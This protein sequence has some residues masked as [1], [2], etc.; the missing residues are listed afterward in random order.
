M[1]TLLLLLAL[2]FTVRSEEALRSSQW[3]GFEK[4]DFTVAGRAALVVKP[5]NAAPGRP[6]IWRTEFFG[7]EPQGDI[8]LLGRGWHVAYFKV[9]NMYGHPDAVALMEK[10]HAHAVREF[11]LAPRA[12]LE[13][14]S[15]G[16]LYAVNFAAAH[17]D[18]TAAL[19]LDAPVL[20]IR[21]WPGGKG[22]GKGD[23]RCWA[24]ALEIYGLTEE[25]AKD[26]KD[27]PLDKVS[28]LA[29]HRIP[30]LFIAGDA[31]EIIPYEENTKIF[32]GKYRA[33]GAPVEVIVKP[34]VNH[35]PH[36]LKDPAPI[37]DFLTKHVK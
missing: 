27:S 21:S 7:H 10:F 17:P 4:L 6:W 19:Y 2:T 14:F 3:N 36:S 29:K 18:K 11:A 31:D 20:D 30:I 28:A 5:A 8:A 32:A 22:K 15:R 23:A 1:R 9:S 37:V 16:G 26:F 35:H 33:E 13:G 34:G 24:Q 25:T 12:V